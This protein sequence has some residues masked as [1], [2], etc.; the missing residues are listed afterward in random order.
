MSKGI[1]LNGL[2][3]GEVAQPDVNSTINQLLARHPDHND[4]P[5]SPYSGVQVLFNGDARLLGCRDRRDWVIVDQFEIKYKPTTIKEIARL[6]TEYY[7]RD[8]SEF[9]PA[10]PDEMTHVFKEEKVVTKPDEDKNQ[11]S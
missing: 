7:D 11:V 3:I 2:G 4:A 9:L 5:N 8:E 6:V 10:D 1:K